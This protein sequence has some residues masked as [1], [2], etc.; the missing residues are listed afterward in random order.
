MC[1]RTDIEDRKRPGSG[2]RQDQDVET[3]AAHFQRLFVNHIQER[4]SRQISGWSAGECLAQDD[5]AT[6]HL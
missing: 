2:P 3:A 1:T 4:F 6:H 5:I